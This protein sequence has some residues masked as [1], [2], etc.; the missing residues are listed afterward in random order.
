MAYSCK[1]IA[2]KPDGTIF[3]ESVHESNGEACETLAE[4][5]NLSEEEHQHLWDE[6]HF[7]TPE[8]SLTV[9]TEEYVP[10]P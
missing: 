9:E 6:L 7:E 1:A 8:F 3:H 5:C 2:T 10:T 4:I